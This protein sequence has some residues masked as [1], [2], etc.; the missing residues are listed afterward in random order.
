MANSLVF[1]PNAAC[2]NLV[3]LRGIIPGTTYDHT[4]HVEDWDC[5]AGTLI[6][7]ADYTNNGGFILWFAD[8]AGALVVQVTGNIVGAENGGKIQFPMSAA[9]TELLRGQTIGR[10]GAAFVDNAGRNMPIESGR[11]HVTD[12]PAITWP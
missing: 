8:A 11:Y 1:T 4:W 9:Q 10:C 6:D 3:V 2:S 5:V 12:W 7:D